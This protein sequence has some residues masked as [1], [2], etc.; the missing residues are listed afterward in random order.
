MTL[1]ELIARLMEL[2]KSVSFDLGQRNVVV[3][4]QVPNVDGWT[5]SENITIQNAPDEAAAVR[6]EGGFGA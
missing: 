2:K 5:H 6:I 4:C 1:D 3:R